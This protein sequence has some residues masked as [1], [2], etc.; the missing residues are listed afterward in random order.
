MDT[1]EFNFE[2]YLKTMLSDK[3]RHIQIIA[4]YIATRGLKFDTKDKVQVAIRRHLRPARQLCAFSDEELR[5]AAE[6]CQ[7][8]YYN[9]DWTLDT[10]LK[11]LTS[12]KITTEQKLNF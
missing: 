7:K 2:D 1:T 11:V 5:Y 12:T 4:K 10:M 8:K 6:F 3:N 9:I